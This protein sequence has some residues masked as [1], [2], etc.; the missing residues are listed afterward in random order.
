MRLYKERLFRPRLSP[1]PTGLDHR[2]RFYW[3]PAPPG[4]WDGFMS[5]GRFIPFTDGCS[6]RVPDDV[7]DSWRVT[8]EESMVGFEVGRLA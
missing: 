2:G 1:P 4:T 5:G 7:P 6:I 3:D 8:V